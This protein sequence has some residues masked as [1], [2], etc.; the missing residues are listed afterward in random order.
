[1]SLSTVYNKANLGVD[2]PLVHL[3][4]GLPAFNLVGLAE[5]TV[6]ELRHRVPSVMINSDFE[7]LS[8][9][10]TTKLLITY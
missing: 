9:R 3:S 6:K 2:T 4:K 5:T 1:M 8:K 10:I 7:F